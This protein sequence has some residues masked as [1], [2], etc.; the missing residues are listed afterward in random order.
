MERPEQSISLSAFLKLMNSRERAA[1]HLSAVSSL[2]GILCAPGILCAMSDRSMANRNVNGRRT[3]S[4]V[5]FLAALIAFLACACR[6]S[7]HSIPPQDHLDQLL[8][9]P[10]RILSTIQ[11]DR[12]QTSCPLVASAVARYLDSG[13]VVKAQRLLRR[14]V[15]VQCSPSIAMSLNEVIAQLEVH[16]GAHGVIT[17]HAG[18]ESE[19]SANLVNIRGTIY[20]VDAYTNP[21]KVT[22]D[23]TND[24]PKK[25]EFSLVWDIR[26]LPRTAVNAAT[27]Y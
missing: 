13:R 19:H 23:F 9:T 4:C 21:T 2:A 11:G 26:S 22:A 16:H 14:Q 3:W 18:Q 27:C 5:R 8:E 1:T 10:S 24:W 25:L 15:T 7:A 12:R 20:L 6:D 17:K